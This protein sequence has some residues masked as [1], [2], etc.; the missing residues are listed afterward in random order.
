MPPA[1]ASDGIGIVFPMPGDDFE[2][3]SIEGISTFFDVR[4]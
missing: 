3:G 2:L 4:R 1:T